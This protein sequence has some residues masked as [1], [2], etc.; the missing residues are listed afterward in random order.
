MNTARYGI[1]ELVDDERARTTH[2]DPLIEPMVRQARRWRLVLPAI[3]VLEVARPL[4]F[5]ASQGLYLF[6]P[7]LRF[8]YREPRIGAYAEFFGKR[9]NVDHLIAC[10]RQNYESLDSVGKESQRWKT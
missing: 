3:L 7:A 8:F 6:E 10:L 1:I 5:I 4:S 2:S 9:S